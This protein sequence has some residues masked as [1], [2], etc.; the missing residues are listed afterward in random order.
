LNSK[1]FPR[2][3]RGISTI[4][5]SL[6]FLVL[7]VSGFSMLTLALD[8]Q[9]DLVDVQRLVSDNEIKKNQEK[10]AIAA[11]TDVNSLLQVHVNNLGK[12]SG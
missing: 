3:R 1:T 6:I 5:G 8:I 2:K 4:V 11:S 12:K 9:I 7:M 10:F